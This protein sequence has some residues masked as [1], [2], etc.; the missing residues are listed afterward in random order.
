MAPRNDRAGANPPAEPGFEQAMERLEAIVE[1][2]EGGQL[3]LEDSLARFEEGQR[4]SQQLTRQ[5]E[6]QLS[7]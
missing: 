1:E 7:E 2:L 6:A 3:T 5:L 4:L